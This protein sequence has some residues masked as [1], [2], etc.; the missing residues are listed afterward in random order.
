MFNFNLIASAFSF[1]G[2]CGLVVGIGFFGIGQGGVK[3]CLSGG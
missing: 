3:H 1:G 2:A